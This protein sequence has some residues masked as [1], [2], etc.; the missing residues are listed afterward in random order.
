MKYTNFKYI[1]E[2]THGIYPVGSWGYVSNRETLDDAI[3]DAQRLGDG[4]RVVN[5]D[6]KVLW[7]SEEQ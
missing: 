3:K 7:P 6:E 5:S 1:I 2:T 4:Y